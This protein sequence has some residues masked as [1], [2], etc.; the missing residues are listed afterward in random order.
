[1]IVQSCVS[2]DERRKMSDS[3]RASGGMIVCAWRNKHKGGVPRGGERGASGTGRE[4][5]IGVNRRQ[6]PTPTRR[7]P[8]ERPCAHP[9]RPI[10]PGFELLAGRSMLSNSR[11][12]EHIFSIGRLTISGLSRLDRSVARRFG[13]N[14]APYATPRRRL[15]YRENEKKKREDPRASFGR[16]IHPVVPHRQKTQWTAILRI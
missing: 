2:V 3:S 13:Q 8:D 5:G 7:C 9:T 6:R 4:S 10:R 14:I 15:W 16:M 12:A 11:R 1:M